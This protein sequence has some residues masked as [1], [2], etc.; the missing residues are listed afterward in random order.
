MPP[1]ADH[2]A[3]YLAAQMRRADEVAEAVRARHLAKA[4][5]GS[6]PGG[7]VNGVVRRA[8]RAGLVR[9][10]TRLRGVRPA[11]VGTRPN[12]TTALGLNIR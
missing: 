11:G 5:I 6:A 2:T 12:A 8:V 3:A 4:G 1:L 10:G 9:L 7:L